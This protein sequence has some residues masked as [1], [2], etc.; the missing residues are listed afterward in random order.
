MYQKLMNSVAKM[1]AAS[2]EERQR[3]DEKKSPPITAKILHHIS[4]RLVTLM[5]EVSES[6]GSEEDHRLNPRSKVRGSNS[7]SAV[8]NFRGTQLP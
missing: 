7:T 1:Q 2:S 3:R 4:S 6:G 8:L 5:H